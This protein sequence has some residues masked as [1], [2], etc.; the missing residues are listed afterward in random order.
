MI[1]IGVKLSLTV[2]GVMFRN[3]AGSLKIWSIWMIDSRPVRTSAPRTYGILMLRAIRSSE[4]PSS[5]AASNSSRGT[6]WSAE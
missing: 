1:M 5:R 2:C 3:S 6:P 4:A